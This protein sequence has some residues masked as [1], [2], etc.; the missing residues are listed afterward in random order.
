MYSQLLTNVISLYQWQFPWVSP[1]LV[2]LCLWKPVGGKGGRKHFPRQ[3]GSVSWETVLNFAPNELSILISP[4]FLSLGRQEKLGFEFKQLNP[5]AF[6]LDQS[7]K[8]LHYNFKWLNNI[9]LTNP[10][11]IFNQ[12]LNIRNYLFP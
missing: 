4:Q 3:L 8:E 10:P 11:N 7:A 12:F 9:M 2:P 1:L 6:V 5:R